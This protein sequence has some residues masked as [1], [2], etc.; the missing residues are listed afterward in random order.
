[1][2]PLLSLPNELILRVIDQL[3]PATIEPLAACGN[4]KV[5]SL[6]RQ[7]LARHRDHKADYSTLVFGGDTIRGR[8][9]E[10]HGW[11]ISSPFNIDDC[12][13]QFISKFIQD[14]D[15]AYYPKTLCL[16]TSDFDGDQYEHGL[17][18]TLGQ[19][20]GSKLPSR[21]VSSIRLC[22]LSEIGEEDFDDTETPSCC[23]W[24]LNT[25]LL[26]AILPNLQSVFIL[27]SCDGDLL[28]ACVSRFVRHVAAAS[29]RTDAT[30][31]NIGRAL[32]LL[33]ELTVEFDSMRS[34][35]DGYSEYDGIDLDNIAT[36]APFAMLPSMRTLQ[37]KNVTGRK[38]SE[39]CS[40]VFRWPFGTLERSL[41]ITTISFI[42]STVNAQTFKS[43]IEGLAALRE[44][45]YHH[46]D[47]LGCA[48]V[49][50]PQDL[51]EVLRTYAADT[52]V[53]LDLSARQ[54]ELNY[55]EKVGQHV[56]SL[57]AFTALKF[58]RADDALFVGPD[59]ENTD[60][61]VLE[62]GDKG[63]TEKPDGDK[64]STNPLWTLLPMTCETLNLIHYRRGTK[65]LFRNFL[66]HKE[67]CLPAL[68]GVTIEDTNWMGVR[69]AE[70]PDP[71]DPPL[72]DAMKEAFKDAGIECSTV[73]SGV[74]YSYR[75]S[76]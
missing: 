19:A 38:H 29:R 5:K 36:Y 75:E 11:R 54:S 27:E 10:R 7:R 72:D 26:F 64:R 41:S 49:Y 9:Q 57:H 74:S 66:E 34:E 45:T 44:F 68:K 24:N 60:E 23:N 1:M 20:V 21:L 76:S 70:W 43:F 40:S 16:D 58:I 55:C 32:P 14:N 73:E 46:E 35:C 53:K 33:K 8:L 67:S 18:F 6:I 30:P 52:L 4:K 37:G 3:H 50:Q 22:P 12:A 13:C 15:L 42:N 59:W 31:H 28:S 62:D 39:N 51:V 61:E 17:E 48:V 56:V 2:F 63:T 25:A 65:E 47:P 69:M 71:L